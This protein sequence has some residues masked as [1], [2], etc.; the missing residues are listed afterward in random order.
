MPERTLWIIRH[1]AAEAP[2]LD[3]EDRDRPLSKAGQDE[4]DALNETLSAASPGLPLD[5]LCIS[6][7]RRTQQTANRLATSL[8][9]PPAH[10][11]VLESLY[12]ANADTLLEELRCT[13]SD[14]ERLGVIAHNPGVSELVSKLT[15]E[16]LRGLPTLGY[17][18]LRTLRSLEDWSELAPKGCVGV[19]H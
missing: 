9:V 19:R 3:Q 2:D 8:G 7:A 17:V 18:V 6:A 12:L 14:C 10:R 5:W 13:P 15:G 16:P 4:C 1:A 11:H